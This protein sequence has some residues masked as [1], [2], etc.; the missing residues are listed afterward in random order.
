MNVEA[1]RKHTKNNEE[2]EF[3]GEPELAL[4]CYQL[5]FA[6]PQSSWHFRHCF[7][8]DETL[9]MITVLGFCLRNNL[10]DITLMMNSARA[11]QIRVI[12]KLALSKNT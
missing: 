1:V 2:T 3:S 5:L 12:T 7:L 4:S 11:S 6:E 9:K 10:H 8:V